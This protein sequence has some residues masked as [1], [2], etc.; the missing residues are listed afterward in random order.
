M[1]VAHQQG[2]VR[3]SGNSVEN[4]STIGYDAAAT[5][6]P[7]QPRRRRPGVE[8]SRRVLTAPVLRDIERN[9]LRAKLARR[10]EPWRWSSLAGW[11]AENRSKFLHAGPVRPPASW[12]GRRAPSVIGYGNTS[13]GR[14][15]W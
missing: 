2:R 1:R 8:A 6:Y 11:Q 5:S 13:H 14:D 12:L 15:V 7:P 9:A 10:A 3:S 4:R